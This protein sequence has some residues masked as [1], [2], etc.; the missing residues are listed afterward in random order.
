MCRTCSDE[1][2]RSIPTQLNFALHSRCGSHRTFLHTFGKFLCTLTQS[3]LYTVT[4]SLLHHMGCIRRLHPHANIQF[5][6]YTHARHTLTRTLTPSPP[7]LICAM[8]TWIVLTST[9]TM[10]LPRD[11]LLTDRSVYHTTRGSCCRRD[12]FIVEHIHTHTN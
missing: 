7:T 8:L 9:I 2:W 5:T 4:L 11:M 3:S 10:T 6:L 12:V 1:P